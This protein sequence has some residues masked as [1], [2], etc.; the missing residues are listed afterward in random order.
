MLV[1]DVGISDVEFKLFT[2]QGEGQVGFPP[3]SVGHHTGVGSYRKI[4]S[5]PFLPTSMCFLH[6]AMRSCLTSFG[7]YSEEIVPYIAVDSVCPW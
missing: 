1:L 2:S 5:Q 4:V 3:D 7:F 6:L